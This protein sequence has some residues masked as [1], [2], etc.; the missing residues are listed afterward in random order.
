LPFS[1]LTTN[2]T[3]HFIPYADDPIEWAVNLLITK[4][5]AQ[6]PFLESTVIIIEE[7]SLSR[8]LRLQLSK[9]AKKMGI[10]ALLG[11][12]ILS[13]R[14]W[15]L[16]SSCEFNAEL[17]HHGRE[18]LLIEA[19]KGHPDLLNNSDPWRLCKTLLT[20]F[21]E[22]TLQQVNIDSDLSAF[23]QRIINAYQLPDQLKEHCLNE[24]KIVHTLWHAWNSYLAELGT[25]DFNQYYAKQLTRLSSQTANEIDKELIFLGASSYKQIENY[26]IAS[27]IKNHNASVLIHLNICELYNWPN[28]KA[29]LLTQQLDLT[30]PL[31][32]SAQENT[33]SQ[34]ALFDQ[35]YQ[36]QPQLISRAQSFAQQHPSS[37]L[38]N[39]LSVFA[40][41]SFEQEAQAIEIQTRLW[42]QQGIPS[43][44][45][46]IENRKLGRRI[47]ALLERSN[48]ASYDLTGWTL[49][50]TSAATVIERWLECLESNFSHHAFLDLLKSR[51]I[52]MIDDQEL[53]ETLIYRL[54]HDII[55]RDNIG[56]GLDNY[57]NQIKYRSEKLDW[58]TTTTSALTT[59]LKQF[60]Q[61]QKSMQPFISDKAVPLHT[62][63]EAFKQSL[64][65]LGILA[66]FKDDAAGSQLLVTLQTIKI[67][68]QSIDVKLN[69]SDFRIY[70]SQILENTHFRPS[71]PSRA[72]SLLS[73]S[74]SKL[75]RFKRLI[76]ASNEQSC[77]PGPASCS[78][79]F[80]H[81]VRAELGLSSW[82]ELATN[83]FDDYRRLLESVDYQ[84]VI[85][86]SSNNKATAL[87]K[88]DYLILLTHTAD[89]EG[90][91]IPASPWLDAIQTFHDLAYGNKL[92]NEFLRYAIY[93]YRS[94]NRTQNSLSKLKTTGMRSINLNKETIPEVLSV[95]NHQQLI[96]CPYQFFC[97]TSLKLRPSD[98]VKEKL[99]KMDYGHRVHLCLQAFHTDLESLPGPFIGSLINS[100][101][102]EAINL[103][104]E[105][106]EAVFAKD[107]KENYQ[108][109][110]WL[111]L[112]T[113]NIPHYID[114]QITHAQQY[115]IVETE[116]IIQKKITKSISIKGIIDRVD[117]A[118][119]DLHC[120]ID[121]KTGVP[122]TKQD[123]LAGESIQLL[124]YALLYD[125]V[126]SIEYLQLSNK[127][128]KSVAR[129][130][131][132][133]LNETKMQTHDR[134]VEMLDQLE[135]GQT[136]NA[137]GDSKTC[138]YC[139]MSGICRQQSWVTES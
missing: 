61:L 38:T 29:K 118:A 42:V 121:Y 48:I 79:Y 26:F 96:N 66:N 74:Q 113:K 49:S 102:T 33:S 54:E 50:S 41:N 11:L 111:L 110:A 8:Q 122:P 131:H 2:T 4:Y 81:Q 109:S 80:N 18:L 20:F 108:H 106:A 104:K 52:N 69:W 114:W 97:A 73:L 44:G 124:S 65:S 138:S 14:D 117:R 78:P 99:S 35:I 72:V 89:N 36:Q 21:D 90:E 128:V 27:M 125:K 47:R 103:L 136:L 19:L 10:N 51:F 83:Q 3:V 94:D 6:L 5:Q 116:Q 39:Q 22:L 56:I 31:A 45:I 30:L 100:N 9:Q 60:K 64:D 115:D 85:D 82:Q 92:E 63:I 25:M 12:E 62:L 139:E 93:N 101:K 71:I 98:E 132:E 28:N 34:K 7:P 16:N 23:S 91:D 129:L 15:V 135:E 24:T 120:L 75:M 32:T 1:N 57:I 88:T 70:L 126:E 59:L 17:I 55:L 84:P 123:V 127:G 134:L 77:F 119:N 53:Y 46:I 58:Q 107:L 68:T 105:I 67:S 40:A 137:W 37:P 95:S 13:L 76:I 43:I 112:W 133:V 87:Q 86:S 130:E